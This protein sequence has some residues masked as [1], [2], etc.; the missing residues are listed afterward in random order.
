MRTSNRKGVLSYCFSVLFTGWL[1]ICAVNTAIAAKT[2]ERLAD[3]A[4]LKGE[5]FTVNRVGKGNKVWSKGVELKLFEISITSQE[6]P[7]EQFN[8][9]FKGPKNASLDK[10]VYLFEQVKTGSF[11]LFIEPLKSDSKNT[12]YQ[13]T[14]NLLKKNIKN[15]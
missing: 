11:S 3:F 12:Y 8:V 7:T 14:F 10:A 4:A 6:G 9:R 2:P 5:V 13:A 15:E 1:L